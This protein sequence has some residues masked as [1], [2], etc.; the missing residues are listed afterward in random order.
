MSDYKNTL[1]L[2]HTEFPMKANLPARE[3]G[4]VQRWQD[5]E[6]YAE[7]RK[8]RHGRPRFILQDGPP[9]AN[10]NI[11]IGHAVNK[12]LKDFVVKS[13]SLDGLDVPYIPGWDCHGLPIEQ[14]VEKKIGK[15][16]HK[17]D[18]KAFRTACR[19]YAAEQVD[20]QR[21]DFV[22]L[23][24]LGDWA[25]PY[26]TM[27][28]HYEGNELRAFAEVI[29]RGHLYKGMKP[30]HWC[31]DCTSALAEAEVEYAD[32]ASPAIDVRFP[33]V[34]PADLQARMGLGDTRLPASVAIWTTTPW[35]LPANQAVALHPEF[36][37]A[38][39]ECDAGRAPERLL[40]AKEL[41][42]SAMQ[43]YGI[44][45]WRIVAGVRGAQ[46]EG[47]KLHHPFYARQVPVILG[48]HVTLDAGTG[49][50]HTSPAHGQ[51][52][53]VAGLAYKLP[54]ENPVDAHG[55]FLPGTELFAGE[56]VF[57]ANAHIIR[58]LAEHGALLHREEIRHSYPH[59]WRHKT[60]VIF[61]A[62]PQWFIGMDAAGLRQQTLAEIPRVRWVPDWGESRIARMV[63]G[64]P[65][66]CISRQRTWGVPIA[67][68]VHKQSG[69]LH[70]R[71][72]ELLEAVAQRVDQAGI[73]AW[74]DLEPAEL[75]SADAG[76][77]EKVTDILDV[78]FDS[79]VVHY[80]VGE[81]R[82]G[83][84]AEAKA[85]LYLEGSD[86]HRGWFMSSLL[87]SVAIRGQAPYKDVLT[88]GFTVDEQGHKMSKSLGNVVAPQAV[89]QRL[90]ADV[91][92][93][94]V[95]ATDYSGE[96]SVSRA[97]LDHVAEAYRKM[98]NTL[99]YLLAN[100]YDFDPD[101]D[102][103]APADML[104]LD[105]WLLERTRRLQ[106]EIRQA[107]ADYQFHLIYQKIY[108]FCVLDL[109]GFYLDVIKDREYTT[110]ADSRARRSCQT[111]LWHVAEAML[112]WLAPV[113]SFTAEEAWGFLPGKRVPTVFLAE[114]YQIAE[115]GT[116]DVP[117]WDALLAMRTT[118]K[119]ELERLRIEGRIGSPL[120]AEVD[121]WCEPALLR[122]VEPVADELRF[123]F[124]TSDARL[125]PAVA[126]A[127]GAV[128]SP[129]LPGLWVLAQPSTHPKCVRCWHHR[130]DIGAN[131]HY[132]DIC[133]RCAENVAGAGEMRRL[134]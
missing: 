130:A 49:A 118:V 127:Q 79:G 110:R 104:L 1:N 2:P 117:L 66:W 54:V 43:R 63:E 105:Q 81:K 23:G 46:L 69:A 34:E 124:I 29:R 62:T 76:E 16:G 60:P 8:A 126:R 102:R 52:D 97:I 109:S 67:L 51:E 33:V 131:P 30:V 58:V 116:V 93:L 71:T 31:M 19:A 6:V 12:I 96:L 73:E 132:P 41:A 9:Y 37:Y 112:R 35:T 65:D 111:A 28:P 91:L 42:A 57:K 85:D 114:W 47:L 94:W 128:E 77:Y 32:I 75:L 44:A 107:Y 134:A 27:D 72:A 17:V 100:L 18:A 89:I 87:T 101:E 88:H 64:R 133:A 5:E 20:K 86:Q 121:L 119:R 98:R 25:H 26:L 59:C 40:L 80:C 82:L 122:R 4:M 38:L 74:F 7:L 53:F 13:R 24:V 78:W 103:V 90:G 3:P 56:H 92:R 68:F 70:P 113:L 115:G 129:E 55:V 36:E 108:N 95:A 50:V 99:R 84:A 21:A 45:T 61:R 14:Q 125:H 15:A 48:E 11:H 120:D 22:R 106:A 10:G 83:L 123:I 39:V